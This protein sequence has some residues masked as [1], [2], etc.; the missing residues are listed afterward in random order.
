MLRL[1]ELAFCAVIVVLGV[2][3][4]AEASGWALQARLFPWV[5]GFPFLALALVQFFFTLRTKAT[6]PVLGQDT[7]EA[8]EIG[9]WNP[10]ARRETIRLGVWVA[11]FLICIALF[12][13]PLGVP[14]AMLLY[15][16]VESKETWLLSVAIAV[17]TWV[18][19]YLLFDMMLHM[20]WPDGLLTSLI[21]R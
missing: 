3:V 12:S 15:L 5:I 16:K 13:F 9:F 2:Y 21:Q 20:A 1:L 17:G 10:E 19:M 11:V 4:V 14:L 7:S 8:E 18:Y 6:V